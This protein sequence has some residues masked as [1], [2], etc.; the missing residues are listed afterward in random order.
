MKLFGYKTIY[1]YMCIKYYFHYKEFVAVMFITLLRIKH[2]FCKKH[3]NSTYKIAN[4][5]NYY[6]RW[7][8]KK[9]IMYISYCIARNSTKRYYIKFFF[10]Q[11]RNIKKYFKFFFILAKNITEIYYKLFFIIARNIMK[12]YNI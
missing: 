11:A 3:I 4:D 6:N 1:I 12:R 10:I 8:N 2:I 9:L 5:F 7:L